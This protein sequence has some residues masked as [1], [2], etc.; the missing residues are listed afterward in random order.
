MNTKLIPFSRRNIFAPL[1]SAVYKISGR[2]LPSMSITCPLFSTN[3]SAAYLGCGAVCEKV[4][5]R[6]SKRERKVKEKI[7]FGSM[8]FDF[9]NF[10]IAIKKYFI[11][12]RKVPTEFFLREIDQ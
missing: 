6:E 2:G 11:S 10:N 4:N 9:N 5:K 12:G 7:F 1:L 3:S 8:F